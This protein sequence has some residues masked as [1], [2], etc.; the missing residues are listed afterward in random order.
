[1]DFLTGFDVLWST[2]LIKIVP[3]LF[4]L[5]VI[6]FFHELGHYA[7]GRLCG[8]RVLTFSIGF[9]PELFGFTDRAGTRW[10]LAAIPLGGYVKFFGDEN[11]AS[12][13]DQ[14]RVR[15]MS[16]S[17]RAEAFPSATVGR[18]A[19]TVLAGPVANFILAIVI[20]AAV[21]F[22]AGRTIGDPV[23]SQVRAGSPAEAAGILP[24][25]RVVALDGGKVEYFS[26]ILEYVATHPASA[27]QVSVNRGGQVLDFSVTPR[28]E[29][30]TDPFGNKIEG[31]LLGLVAD[32]QSADFRLEKLGPID[33]L[34]YGV[35]QTWFFTKATV[36]FIGGIFSRG[37][38]A[39]Q[40]G[41]PVRIAQVSSQVATIGFAA[42]MLLAAQLSI[43]IGLLNLLPIPMLD[44]G[45][46]MFYVA[47]ALRGRPL[48]ERVQEFGFKV[49][50]VLVMSLMVFAFWNDLS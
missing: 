2:V 20:F 41:G 11:A 49:G 39:E 31:P 44:G 36:G 37:Q 38:G 28:M 15:A 25:D 14:D 30:Q 9:G 27:I 1:M 35:E 33:S 3:F 13:P 23:V 32:R 17:E 43:S 48:S 8:I 4:V 26:D 40:I 34:R 7:I 5:T 29:S 19:A 42:I 16:A 45:H 22:F 21:A 50:L 47:E 12:V 46:L 10:R 24:G 18:R 6:V